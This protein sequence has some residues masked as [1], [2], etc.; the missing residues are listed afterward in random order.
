MTAPCCRSFLARAGGPHEAGCPAAQPKAATPGAVYIDP[1][2][3][4]LVQLLPASAWDPDRWG[5]PAALPVVRIL[6]PGACDRWTKPGE[7]AQR[8]LTGLTL[9][10]E[11][12][13]KVL[14][15][16][17]ARAVEDLPVGT[18]GDENGAR[19]PWPIAARKVRALAGADGSVK[20][21]DAPRR[22]EACGA[23][24]L[25]DDS[26]RL[27]FLACAVLPEKRR[28]GEEGVEAVERKVEELLAR[29]VR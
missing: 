4:E 23:Q 6:A 25:S 10:P 19:C 15:E 11:H 26:A 7:I 18:W 17:C 16:C 14:V 12:V 28:R 8:D 21:V 3:G 9:V 22:C 29:G 13:F 1:G 5:P 20:V 27:H 2:D 24:V